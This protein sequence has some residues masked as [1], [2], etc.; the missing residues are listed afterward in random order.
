MA[1]KPWN[2]YFIF[3]SQ[4]GFIPLCVEAEDEPEGEERCT[5]GLEEELKFGRFKVSRLETKGDHVEADSGGPRQ[6]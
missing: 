4:E 2:G 3:F 5:R 6:T 1:R